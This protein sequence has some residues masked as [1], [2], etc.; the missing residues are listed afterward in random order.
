MAQ[1][2]AG[3]AKKLREE[4]QKKQTA[5]VI[6]GSKTAKIE[7]A[8][9]LYKKAA[10]LLKV[11]KQDNEAAASYMDAA[12]CYHQTPNNAHEE[13]TCFV[14]A[15]GC[16]RKES[17]KLAVAALQNAINIYTT[18]GRFGVAAKY[19]KEIAEL[20]E[21]NDETTSAIPH[22]ETAAQYF[23]S[24]N[25]TSTANGCLLKVAQFCADAKDFKKAIKLFEDVSKSSLGNK[26]TTYS[27][28]DYLFKAM[29]CILCVGD[30]V[31]AKKSLQKYIAMDPNLGPSRE[32]KL[33]TALTDAFENRDEE[34]FEA[35]LDEFTRITPL[36]LWKNNLVTIIQERIKKD[37]E[38]DDGVL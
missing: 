30:I 1:D 22:Y 33:V 18:D 8:A 12:N 31:E 38:D 20:Y 21:N 29:L 17:Y 23:E 35:A 26:L 13:A 27:V 4:A 28:K 14:K 5:T 9:E 6:I 11:A 15:A 24:E 19:E 32:C 2:H 16:Y 10:N 25:S 34:L 36:D 3:Q 37:D 7:E